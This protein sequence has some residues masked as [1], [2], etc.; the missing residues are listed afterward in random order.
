MGA[1]VLADEAWEPRLKSGI[2]SAV[3]R[4]LRAG[5]RHITSCRTKAVYDP[6]SPGEANTGLTKER[7]EK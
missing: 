5:Q 2:C 6:G 7:D 3:S 4:V 1:S